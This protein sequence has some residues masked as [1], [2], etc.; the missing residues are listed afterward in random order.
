MTAMPEVPGILTADQCAATGAAIAAM[1]E[2]SGALPWFPGGQTDPWDHVES[3]MA[4]SV[5]GFHAEAEAAYRL[6]QD[7]LWFDVYAF[8]AAAA[9]LRLA[10]L[11]RAL[12]RGAEAAPLEASLAHLWSHAD[13]GLAER[14][15]AAP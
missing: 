7:P 13:P 9:R 2:A 5:T 6:A 1:Q 4:L 14:I 10:H 8:T 3:A 15:L 11:L 12:G